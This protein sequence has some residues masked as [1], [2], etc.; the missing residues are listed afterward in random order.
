MS[1]FH[2]FFEMGMRHILDWN[3][4][5]HLLFVIALCLSFSVS[6]WKKIIGLLSAFTIGHSLSL[7]LST[8][9]IIRVN[10]DIV[11]FLI[12]LTI[13]L[14]GL[15]HLIRGKKTSQ[16]N[17]YWYGYGIVIAFGLIHGMGFSSYLSAL[18]GRS[19]SIITP[20]LAFNLGLE[21][22]QIVIVLAYFA[23]FYLL[24]TIINHLQTYWKPAWTFIIL[25]V[26]ASLMYHARFW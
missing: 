1:T 6:S 19:E 24:N 21:V 2:V 13:F 25:A 16:K 10:S 23:L 11:E 14:T 15:H 12:P 22:G 18:L 26:S 7:A 9:H 3:G 5:D 4:Y 20:L 17:S 8:L